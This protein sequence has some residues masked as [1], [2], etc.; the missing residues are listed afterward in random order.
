MDTEFV[1]FDTPVDTAL[2]ESVREAA[3]GTGT[4]TG[5]SATASVALRGRS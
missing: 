4:T 2:P 3:S 1:E 5:S